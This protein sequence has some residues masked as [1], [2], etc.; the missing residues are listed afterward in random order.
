M[1]SETMK[2]QIETEYCQWVEAGGYKQSVIP[3]LETTA[4]RYHLDS[5]ELAEWM[6]PL[7]ERLGK[8][9]FEE[10]RELDRLADEQE[11]KD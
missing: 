5:V 3:F 11:G 7:C 4:E 9:K 10:A 2:R 1:I 6:A 8:E